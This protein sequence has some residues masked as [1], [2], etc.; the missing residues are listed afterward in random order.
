VSAC[1]GSA[2]IWYDAMRG[3]LSSLRYIMLDVWERSVLENKLPK[4]E[5]KASEYQLSDLTRKH[6][7]FISFLRYIFIIYHHYLIPLFSPHSQFSSLSFCRGTHFSH[8]YASRCDAQRNYPR[9]VRQR[10]RRICTSNVIRKKIFICIFKCVE[11]HRLYQLIFH[12]DLCL[13]CWRNCSSNV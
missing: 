13:F 4:I 1:D 10:L 11:R 7:L 5:G 9:H 8:V 2:L 12:D 3:G 6:T